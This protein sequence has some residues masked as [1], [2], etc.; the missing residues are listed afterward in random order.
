MTQIVLGQTESGGPVRVDLPTLIETRLLVQAMSGGGKSWTLRR[1][2]EQTHGKVQH[3]VLDPEGEFASLRERFDY[4]LIG[5][6]GDRAAK[7]SEAGALARSVLELQC[8]V[9]CDLYE[10]KVQERRQFVRLFLEALVNAPKALWHPALVV[11]DE[12]HSFAPEG[13]QAESSGAVIDLLSRGRKR[14]FCAVLATQRL[15]K[16]D[17]N[18]AAE[19]GN[20]M[21][22]RTVQDVD[23]KRALEMLAVVRSD[24]RDMN[25]AL[26]T[27][28]AGSF[29]SVGGAF[30]PQTLTFFRVGAV[31]TQHPAIGRGQMVAPTP[32]PSSRIQAVLAKLDHISRDVDEELRERETLRAK[33]RDLSG[34][35]GKL[36]RELAAERAKPGGE[37]EREKIAALERLLNEAGNTARAAFQSAMAYRKTLENITCEADAALESPAPEPLT[38][39]P[40]PSIGNYILDSNGKLW[41]TSCVREV[42]P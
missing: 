11:V 17:K 24:H 4:V 12:A 27:L 18:A 26:M 14:G 37:A 3:I 29:Y 20:V 1:L 7:P 21:V 19:C 5:K 36:E 16:L 40:A 41:Y 34:Q 35:V 6:G 31:Q 25:A 33:V 30:Q 13:S 38:S 8:N 9:I 10:L 2:L 39:A 22:G 42:K 15:A 32:P 28:P 23:R